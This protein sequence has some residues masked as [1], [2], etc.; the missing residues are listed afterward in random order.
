M[1]VNVA[2]ISILVS[3]ACISILLSNACVCCLPI[4]AACLTYH[5]TILY[6]KQKARRS[7]SI[8]FKKKEIDTKGSEEDIDY[9]ESE[10]DLE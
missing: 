6:R 4:D 2:C 10:D 8:A 3:D 9:H 5:P 1:P 7:R